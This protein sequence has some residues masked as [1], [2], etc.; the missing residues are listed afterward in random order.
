MLTSRHHILS[1]MQ[2][3]LLQLVQPMQYGKNQSFLLALTNKIVG[4]EVILS[5]DSINGYQALGFDVQALGVDVSTSK[6]NMMEDEFTIHTDMPIR[7]VQ[8]S[9]AFMWSKYSSHLFPSDVLASFTCNKSLNESFCENIISFLQTDIEGCLSSSLFPSVIADLEDYLKQFHIT[10]LNIEQKSSIWDQHFENAS[11]M[12]T[13]VLKIKKFATLATV[14]PL[15]LFAS[16][17]HE[18]FKKHKFLE[19][20]LELIQQFTLQL[21]CESEEYSLFPGDGVF[22]KL[23]CS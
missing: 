20:S 18:H 17:I 23:V 22:Y 13:I 14:I 9:D 6:Q 16:V 11:T 1:N 21:Q 8:F 19:T 10:S 12:K 4:S 7:I 5:H 15:S 2:D 3:C